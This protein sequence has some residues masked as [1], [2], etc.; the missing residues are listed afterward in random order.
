MSSY[1][2]VFYKELFQMAPKYKISNRLVILTIDLVKMSDDDE[3]VT[4]DYGPSEEF[5]A[6]LKKNHIWGDEDGTVNFDDNDDG[7]VEYTFD[8]RDLPKIEEWLSAHGITKVEKPDG[9]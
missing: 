5:N 4:E 1:L 7:A 9:Q 3:G 2:Q 6:W 8:E